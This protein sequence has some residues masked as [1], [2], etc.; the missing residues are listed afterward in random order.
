MRCLHPDHLRQIYECGL[1]RLYPQGGRSDALFRQAIMAIRLNINEEAFIHDVLQNLNGIGSKLRDRPSQARE[2]YL[3]GLWA[4][5]VKAVACQ[6]SKGNAWQASVKAD[7]TLKRCWDMALFVASVYQEFGYRDSI[8]VTC[9]DASIA[10][11]V[12]RA[13]AHRHLMM[14]VKHGYLEVVENGDPGIGKA[15]KF[16]LVMR[17]KY[18]PLPTTSILSHVSELSHVMRDALHKRSAWSRFVHLLLNG[19]KSTQELIDLLAIKTRTVEAHLRRL[20]QLGMIFEDQGRWNLVTDEEVWIRIAGD[21]GTLGTTVNRQRQYES[22][23]RDFRA[24]RAK[25]G[26]KK[27]TPASIN[28]GK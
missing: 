21:R 25:Y 7:Q 4:N 3:R 11:R 6:I 20:R 27:S 1:T 12:S 9:R 10:T 24:Y 19:P 15:M 18:T 28:T 17:Q 22:E 26:T 13:S 5:A 8:I 16:R 2:A 23:R 14:L